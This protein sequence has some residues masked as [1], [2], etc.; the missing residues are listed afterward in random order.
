MIRRICLLTI[1]CLS[2]SVLTVSCGYDAREL[3]HRSMIAGIAIDRAVEEDGLTVSFQ[4]PVLGLGTEVSPRQKDF[5]VISSSDKT[6][7]EAITNIETSTPRALFFGHLKVVAISEDVAKDNLSE[8]LDVL[9]RHPQ[10]GN[11]VYLLI[12]EDTSAKEFLS[13][14]TPLISLPSL[15]VDTFFKA[16]QKTTRTTDTQLF[17]YLRDSHSA[18]D[19]GYIPLARIKEGIVHIQ[20]LA[21]LKNHR[22]VGVLRGDYAGCG[23][24]L[25]EHVLKEK[26][27]TI[28]VKDVGGQE[29][30]VNLA[31]IDLKLGMTYKKTKPVEFDLDIEGSGFIRGLNVTHDIVTK[32]FINEIEKSIN[33]KFEEEFLS[34]IKQTQ[35]MNAEPFLFGQYIFA[36]DHKFFKSLNWNEVGWKKA[37]VNITVKF[38]VENTGT[39]NYYD[40]KQ[41]GE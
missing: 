15:Y 22:M 35:K 39:K 2:F 30:A 32:K 33:K 5:E 20:D 12:I 27:Y 11:Q 23:R 34:V 14:K 4:L 26:R 25:R 37:K 8:V 10:V 3:D 7:M 9:E 28:R 21:I 29:V 41:I 6:I 31:K 17:E 40:K 1:V 24:L 38:R 16:R 36:N 13:V 18:S 19:S